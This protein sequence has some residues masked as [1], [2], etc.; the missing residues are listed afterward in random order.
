MDQLIFIIWVVL[1]LGCGIWGYRYISNLEAEFKPTQITVVIEKTSTGYSAFCKE[2]D[3]IIAVE[4]NIP[5]LKEQ[6]H[7]AFF[8]WLNYTEGEF[9]NMW[10]SDFE[11]TFVEE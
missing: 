2:I 1:A 11:I 4:D 3:G 6:F 9:A 8:F 7:E 10:P 5:A